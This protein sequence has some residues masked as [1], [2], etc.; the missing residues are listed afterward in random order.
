MRQK[1][2]QGSH[3]AN[4]VQAKGIN[5]LVIAGKVDPCMSRVFPFSGTAEC[6]QLMRDNKHPS[7]NMAI[8]VNSPRPGLRTV[9]E[10]RA[11]RKP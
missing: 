2:L 3:F 6:H 9:A 7:G 11:A 1:R 10:V 8:L 5:D 4:D